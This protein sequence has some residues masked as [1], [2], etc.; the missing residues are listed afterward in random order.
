[1]NENKKKELHKKLEKIKTYYSGSL[2][3]LILMFINEEI[4]ETTFRKH[5]EDII[6]EIIYETKE[7]IEASQTT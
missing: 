2:Y 3:R 7:A 1:M 5:L 4:D 6:D